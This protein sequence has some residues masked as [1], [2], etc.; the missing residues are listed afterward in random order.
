MW[1]LNPDDKSTTDGK[2]RLHLMTADGSDLHSIGGGIE[3][4]GTAAWS[5]DGKW[6]VTGGRGDHGLGL[7]KISVA[8]GS[9]AQILTGQAFN[10]V[11]SPGLQQTRVRSR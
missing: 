3:V 7:F 5:P 10:P 4:R 1:A 8:G 6:I 9:P 2:L 11:W